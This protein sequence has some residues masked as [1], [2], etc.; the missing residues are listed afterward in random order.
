MLEPK[1]LLEGNR[2]WA[3][4]TRREDPEFFEQLARGQSPRFFWIGCSDSR[5]TPDR[6]MNLRPGTVFVHRNVA[7]L[8]G[9]QDPNGLAALSFAVE[10]LK[11]EH[12]IV[13]GHTGCGGIKACLAGKVHGPA[14]VWLQPLQRLAREREKELEAMEPEER[15]DRLAEL[16]VQRQVYN[17]SHT[18]TVREAWARGQKLSLH[19]WI[20]SIAEGRLRDL[21]VSVSGPDQPCPR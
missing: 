11:V 13:C 16:N 8:M 15:A 6:A 20:F 21:G 18:Q 10:V 19:R 3:E 7:N 12:V 14:G 17:L 1:D 4:I 5:V 2:V 9:L